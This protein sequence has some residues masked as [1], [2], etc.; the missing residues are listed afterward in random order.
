M[1]ATPE[2]CIVDDNETVRIALAGLVRSPGYHAR[3]FAS[4]DE[5]LSS[6]EVQNFDCLITDIQVPGMSGIELKQ[7][8]T[9]SNCPLAR[10]ELALKK[11]ALASGAVNLLRKPFARRPSS[12]A[13]KEFWTRNRQRPLH[14]APRCFSLPIW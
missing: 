14:K 11:R 12:I 13:C 10:P 6:G 9:A 5:F 8:L 3:S 7:H 1:A 4:A 2:I